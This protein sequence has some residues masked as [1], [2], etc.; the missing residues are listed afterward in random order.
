MTTVLQ[1]TTSIHSDSAASSQL[2][3][4]FTASLKPTRILR[5]DLAVD[6]VPHLDAEKFAAFL[7]PPE[8]R[9]ARQQQLAGESDRLISELRQADVLVLGL[10]MYN[11]GIPS[12][13]KAWFDHV[14]RA[15][16]TF[17]YTAEGPVGLLAG[18]KAYVIATRGGRYAGTDA[19]TQS[20]YVRGFLAFLGITDVT[21][22]Y[23]EG[24]ALGPQAR[25]A[26]L[27]DARTTLH[28]LGKPDRLAA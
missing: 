20:S 3:E 14:G 23:A 22:V 5:R 9:S 8:Q 26:S 15:G 1:L 17:R 11:F 4:E 21:F 2:A 25:E 6:P 18:R 12:T 27:A 10:P 24:L 16:Q 13:L 19:D 28:N 7:A